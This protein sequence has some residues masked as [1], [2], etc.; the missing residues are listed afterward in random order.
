ML[1]AQRPDPAAL[2]PGV[3][4]AGSGVVWALEVGACVA[5]RLLWSGRDSLWPGSFRL[6]RGAFPDLIRLLDGGVGAAL[7]LA[8]QDPD[9]G[10]AAT[11]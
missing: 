6:G 5:G 11:G 4:A 3:A 10:R 9:A 2:V 1:R 7:R 8:R